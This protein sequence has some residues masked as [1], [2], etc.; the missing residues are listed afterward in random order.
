MEDYIA[1]VEAWR[2]A[3]EQSYTGDGGWLAQIALVPLADE[4][5]A[6]EIGTFAATPEGARFRAAPDADV[7]LDGRRVDDVVLRDD[8]GGTPDT[9]VVGSRR[10]Q[11][12]RR[13]DALALRVRDL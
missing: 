2:R 9:L 6:D 7:R 1:T 11:I 3:H 13:G 4:P 8:R 5:L 10:Y 12:V